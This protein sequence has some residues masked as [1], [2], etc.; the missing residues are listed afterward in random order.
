MSW[1]YYFPTYP[2]PPKPT[3]E[4]KKRQEDEVTAYEVIVMRTPT[5][6]EKKD[7]KMAEVVMGPKLVVARDPQMAAFIFACQIPDADRPSKEELGRLTLLI[8]T[9]GG[10]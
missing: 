8:S 6:N 10:S 1:G 4:I 3:Q 5:E 7:G 2:I 9:K